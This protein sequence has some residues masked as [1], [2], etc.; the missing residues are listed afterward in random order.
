[1]GRLQSPVF[2]HRY[3]ALAVMS[4]LLPLVPGVAR[5]DSLPVAADAHVNRAAPAANFGAMPFLQAGNGT[6][7]Y[8]RFDTSSL[9]AGL[10]TSP[11]AR[12]NLVL[13]VRTVTTGGSLQV[14]NVNGAWAEN[15]LTYNTQPGTGSVVGVVAAP[16][17][18][19]FVQ[20]D[21]TASFLIWLA[22][23]AQNYG[24]VVTGLPSSTAVTLDSKETIST[25]HAPMLDIVLGGPAGATGAVGPQGPTG[26][27]G[28]TGAA[29]STGARGATGT[30]GATGV[31]GVTG[32]RGATGVTGAAGATGSAGPQ[33]LAGATGATGAQ[34]PGTLAFGTCY[35]GMCVVNVKVNSTTLNTAHV[36]PS[37][38]F[39]VAFDYA[40]IGTGTYC[41]DC[42]EQYYVGVT[43]EA[44][45]GS[46][47]NLGSNC[48]LNTVFGD[49]EQVGNA[50]VTLTAPAA[51]GVYYIAISGPSLMDFCPA[52][53][54]GL[55]AASASQYIGVISVY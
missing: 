13:W 40:S 4:L 38:R 52:A 17:A 14:S 32:A 6:S 29:G 48:F 51:S 27:F 34:G 9:P 54:G 42:I 26:A 55:G 19:Q 43:N 45:T 8:L 18:E 3:R 47:P 44:V 28:A 41:P 15:T 11:I 1:M 53:P 36:S 20:V 24:L 49:T 7:A 39:T 16:G 5:A 30:T 21:V 33:G 37:A 22:S 12:V 10:L 50:S 23:P 25:S 46:S 31:T 2:Q 35:G